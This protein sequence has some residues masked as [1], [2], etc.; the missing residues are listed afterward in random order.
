MLTGRLFVA[1]VAGCGPRGGRR[2]GPRGPVGISSAVV[3]TGL[4]CGGR[5]VLRLGSLGGLVRSCAWRVLV[6]G[7]G[8]GSRGF[9]STGRCTR[10]WGR[11]GDPTPRSWRRLPGLTVWRGGRVGCVWFPRRVRRSWL[12]PLVRIFGPEGL[13]PIAVDRFRSLQIASDRWRSEFRRAEFRRSEFGRSEFGRSAIGRGGSANALGRC[14]DRIAI[15]A[16][17]GRLPC[18]DHSR[19]SSSRS[20]SPHRP[21]SG[22]AAIQ[23]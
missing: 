22:R 9:A 17:P 11:A 4:R 15:E 19:K 6:R 7:R 1:L 5:D 2:G 3:E 21:A 8:C 23:W 16:M 12:P 14:R 18:Q 10:A 20:R 13:A